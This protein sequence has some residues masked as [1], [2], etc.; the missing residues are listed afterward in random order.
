MG[1]SKQW[2]RDYPIIDVSQCGGRGVRNTYARPRAHRG[3]PARRQRECAHASAHCGY[4]PHTHTEPT[5]RSGLNIARV[6]RISSPSRRPPPFPPQ[7]R[8]SVRSPTDAN[9]RYQEA[10]DWRKWKK[11]GCICTRSIDRLRAV[12]DN[13]AR[14]CQPERRLNF[15]QVRP[16]PA[17]A[18]LETVYQN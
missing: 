13:A 6:M 12:T 9:L 2:S 11:E 14:P 16:G 5:Q 7:H 1:T 15:L 3:T 10:L 17:R 4:P 18:S 8:A